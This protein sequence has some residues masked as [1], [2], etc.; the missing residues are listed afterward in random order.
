MDVEG[1]CTRQEVWSKQ[2]HT[3]RDQLNSPVPWYPELISYK[4]CSIIAGTA[5]SGA[6]YL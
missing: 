2:R 1:K 5:A 3:R 6:C 4:V